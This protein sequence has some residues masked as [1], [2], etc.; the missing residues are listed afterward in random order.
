MLR[1][2]FNFKTK[3][4]TFAAVILGLSTLANGFLGIIRDRLL[5][6][7][8]GASESLDIYF[9]A[10]RIP[11][12]VYGILIAG[13][14]IAVFLPVFSEY[15]SQGE[16]E[17]WYFTNT[18]LNCFLVLT[19]VACLIL[20]IFTPQF[21]ELIAPGFNQQSQHLTV[22]LTRIMLLSPIFFVVSSFFSGI[23]HYFN[24]FLIYSMAPI[25][26]NVGIILGIVL[27]TPIFGILG[28]AYGVA[29]GAFLY[30]IIQIPSAVI[31]GFRYRPIF[32]FK[33]PGLKKV[34]KLLIPRIIGTAASQLNL[35]IIT[36]IASTLVAGSIA[37]FNFSNNIQKFP[38]TLIGLSFAAAGFPV[39]ARTW[40]NGQ[41][42]EFLESFFSIFRQ[43]LFLIIPVSF[44][45]FIFRMQGV[46]LI[47]RTGEFG[48]SETRLTAASMG[49]FAFSIFSFT[50]I[51][52]VTRAFFSFQDT[53]TPVTIGIISIVL[54]IIFCVFFVWLLTDFVVFKNFI[55]NI[56]KLQGID[57]IRLLGLPIGL[58]LSG[59][60]NLF[61][62][63]I[64]LYK[65]MK[66]FEPAGEQFLKKEMKETHR[67]LNKILIASFLMVI[68]TYFTLKISANFL[69]LDTFLG[70][71][72]Q[73]VAAAAVGILV[74]ILTAFLLNSTEF[75]DIIRSFK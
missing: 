56:L 74:Y 4:V 71:L 70:L 1:K 2:F 50:L 55:S 6:R 73:T 23:L 31:S 65:K 68:F 40:I 66:N 69:A 43:T 20:L 59:I 22:A 67:S 27:F 54:N 29:I 14:I 75:K 13:G 10:F 35:T 62:L 58:S 72:F 32:D 60:L 17:G 42:K 45:M 51:P 64:Y 25:L 7:N 5:A 37:I 47:L 19:V 9:A 33:H 8:F 21:I 63:L 46:S 15:F 44:F 41:K 53:K 12:F 26:Y 28:L 36:A 39:L 38:A 49:I 18:V 48:W 30:L 52:L 34:V 57:N 61:L 3:T 16:K 24:H 11:D